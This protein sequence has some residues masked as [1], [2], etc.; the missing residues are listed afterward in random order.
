M[1]YVSKLEISA[2]ASL[3]HWRGG[4][5]YRP[6]TRFGTAYR[7]LASPWMKKERAPKGPPANDALWSWVL[8]WRLAPVAAAL[9]LWRQIVPELSV[10]RP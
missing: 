1:S 4:L 7:N 3:P 5:R 6:D 9:W 10:S 2:L 8:D